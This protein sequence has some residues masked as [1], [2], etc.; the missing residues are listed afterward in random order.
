MRGLL[1]LSVICTTV[2][3]TD[4]VYELAQARYNRTEYE[5]SLRLLLPEPG[6]DAPTLALIGQNYL[7]MGDPK[8]A[9][10]FF[11]R[12]VALEPAN[13]VYHHWLGR[14]Y[15][16]LAETGSMLTALGNASKA[17]QHFEKAIQLDPQNADARHDLFEFYVEAPGF[18]GGGLDKAERLAVLI[19]AHDAAEGQYA[20]ARIAEKRKEYHGAEAHLRQAMELAPRQ[21]GRV[22]DLAKF[23]A[24]HGRF[25]ESDRTFQAAEKIAPS[26]PKLMFA[27]A[28]TYIEAKRNIGTAR[29]LLRKYLRAQLT[30]DDPPRSEALKLLQQVSGG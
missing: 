15:G 25:D 26:A 8:D 5:A 18:L 21:V 4:S 9:G 17:R 2:F 23:L 27:R 24:Q 3:A 19:A 11:E 28:S 7:M 1:L 6:K 13:S 22:I 20:Q 30:P 10:D 29:S 12:A 16:R 14:A